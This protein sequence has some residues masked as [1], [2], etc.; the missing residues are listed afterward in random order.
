MTICFENQNYVTSI[1]SPSQTFQIDMFLNTLFLKTS[2]N[3]M[4]RD[5]RLKNLNL[6]L[7]QKHI[8]AFFVVVVSQFPEAISRKK[9]LNKPD[10]GL[11]T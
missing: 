5:C 3:K 9:T 1:R 2:E 7:S 8:V 10:E 6:S 11:Y 4:M